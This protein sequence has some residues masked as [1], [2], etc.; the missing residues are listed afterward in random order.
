MSLYA[1]GDLHLSFDERIEKPMDIFGDSWL[2]HHERLKENWMEIIEEDDTVL[3]PGDVSWGLRFDEAMA[4][5]QWI[6][7]LPGHKVI[8]KGNH[9]LWWTSISKMNK[10]F[11]DITFLQNHCYLIPGTGICIC[12]TRGWIC[13]GIEGFDEHDQ[14]IYDREL[15]RLEFSLAEARKL[16]AEEI[17]AALHYPPTNDKLQTS[18]FTEMLSKYGVNTCIYGHLHGKE[19]FKNGIKGVL[20]GVE[21][22]LVSL[23][24]LECRPELIRRR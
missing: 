2:D 14:K 22:R 6:H 21:Y 19:A 17:I 18:G 4:D 3:I 16:G 9:D 20:N 12:G 13:P 24:Y 15:L 1:I 11:D 5:F 7:G 10:I 8:T 23:D